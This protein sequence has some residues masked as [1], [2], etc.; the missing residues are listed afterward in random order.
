M[1]PM[2]ALRW[3]VSPGALSVRAWAGTLSGFLGCLLGCVVFWSRW[4]CLGGFFFWRGEVSMGTLPHN[5]N[6]NKKV[7][8]GICALVKSS[9]VI[10]LKCVMSAVQPGSSQ[11]EPKPGGVQA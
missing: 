5:N 10:R 4:V 2:M 11:H 8:G 6:N 9:A 3:N 7:F 1:T